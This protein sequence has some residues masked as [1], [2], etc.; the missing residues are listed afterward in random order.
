LDQEFV[1]SVMV[2]SA[3]IEGFAGLSP[4]LEG[5][6]LHPRMPTS[7]PKLVINGIAVHQQ[8]IDVEIEPQKIHLTRVS[9][10][11]GTLNIFPPAGNWKVSMKGS[12]GA[13]EAKHYVPLLSERSPL[14]WNVD[15]FRELTLEML[16]D[17]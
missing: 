6:H 1:E 8:V 16:S 10:D 15:S 9:S 3:M 11:A 4:T 2:P 17:K 7:W 13:V 12:T 14:P 5:L